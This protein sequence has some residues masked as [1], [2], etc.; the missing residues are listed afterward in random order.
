MANERHYYVKRW[1]NAGMKKRE[2]TKKKSEKRKDKRGKEKI[3]AGMVHPRPI[4]IIRTRVDR[5]KRAETETWALLERH[6]R[7][8]PTTS[9]AAFSLV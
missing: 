5:D 2:K 8:A 9:F 7:V 6:R 4:T 1:R 3:S